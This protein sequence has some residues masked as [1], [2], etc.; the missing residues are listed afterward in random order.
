MQVGGAILPRRPDFVSQVG[1][2]FHTYPHLL[3]RRCHIRSVLNA[4]YRGWIGPSDPRFV[5][6]E[7]DYKRAAIEKAAARL[8][9]S[10]LADLI[11]RGRFTEII[12]RLEEIGQAT[13]LLYLATPRTGDLSIL[14]DPKLDAEAFAGAVRDLLHGEGEPPARLER[15]AKVGGQPGASKP[16]DV[17]DVLSL[18]HA[19]REQPPGQAPGNGPLP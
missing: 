15:F 8:S 17:P 12:E 6:D 13:N 16:L 14:Y 4:A 9:N 2:T 11:G 18:P 10:A 7:I 19:P 3:R 1:H 5:K